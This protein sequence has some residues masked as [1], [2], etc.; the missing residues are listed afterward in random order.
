L[1]SDH[2]GFNNKVE[3]TGDSGEIIAFP[4]AFGELD[5]D[6]DEGRRS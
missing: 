3:A 5:A 4:L 2:E 1:G 6:Q